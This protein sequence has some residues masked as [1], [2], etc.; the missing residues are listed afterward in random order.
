MPPVAVDELP[1]SGAAARYRRVHLEGVYEYER[2]FATGPRAHQG[3]PGVHIVTP[4]RRPAS[5][6][7]VLAVRGWAYAPDA[8]TVELERWREGDSARVEGYTLLLEPDDEASSGSADTARTV[9]RLN[10]ASLQRRLGAP[11]AGYYVVVTSAPDPGASV[12]Q[13]PVRVAEPSLTDGPHLSYAVQWFLFAVV[14]G[15]G[16]AVVVLKG[17]RS[18]VVRGGA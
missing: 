3:S 13:T 1:D 14:F 12:A 16:G 2:E 17:R 8:R 18:P 15:A 4:V 7:L 9:R 5:D 6:T 10:R 11:V